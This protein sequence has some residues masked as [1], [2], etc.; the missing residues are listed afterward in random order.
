MES[1]GIHSLDLFVP[2]WR[3][4]MNCADDHSYLQNLNYMQSR[5]VR[6]KP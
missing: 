3:I 5:F 2:R 6:R 1:D 4:P